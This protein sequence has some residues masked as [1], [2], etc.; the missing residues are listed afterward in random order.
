MFYMN[1]FKNNETNNC[2]MITSTVS[3]KEID[4]ECDRRVEESL[5]RE[6]SFT[7]LHSGV[8]RAVGLLPFQDYL[9]GEV[10]EP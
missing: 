3:S 10:T 5:V 1:K 7:S 8:S 6:G 9:R 2:N 4:L